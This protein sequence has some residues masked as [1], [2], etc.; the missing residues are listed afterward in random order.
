MRNKAA[1]IVTPYFAPQT[2]A[3]V[4]RAYKLAKYL[5][6]FG[7]R[8][9]VVTV[10]K[11]Y[12]Y[13]EDRSLTEAL[14]PEVEVYRARYVEPTLRG[15]R[16][17]LGGKDRTF[18]SLKQAG[19]TPNGAHSNGNGNGHHSPMRSAYQYA[20]TRWMQDPDP[21]W[22]WRRPAVRLATRLIREKNISVV[23]TSA[24]P[25]TCHQIGHELQGLGCRWVADLRD[26]HTYCAHMFSPH[27]A[28]FHHQRSAEKLA[29]RNADAVTVASS[30]IGMI[31]TDTYGLCSAERIH[32]IPTG[33]DEALLPQ[34][35]ET[36]GSPDPY[37]L[38]T[39]EFLPEYGSG[40][41][42]IFSRAMERVELKNTAW[43]LVFAGRR[44]VN[45]PLV[46][47]LAAKLGI[48]VRVQFIDHLPQT[49]LYRLLNGA[50]AAILLSGRLFR[51]W[52]L[53]AKMVDYI[54][55]KKPVIA[56][57]PDTSEARTRLGESRLGVFLDGDLEQCA[58]TLSD[59]LLG[60]VRPAD[61]DESVC[62]R[63]T[64]RQQVE[65][66]VNVFESIQ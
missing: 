63:Y 49:E 60:R 44:E 11:N 59:F 12:L 9:Y 52:C 22:T 66:F 33:L 39:G 26:P 7:W 15:L 4:F 14:P 21:Y 64:A 13:N 16:M 37:L 10:D 31:L 54:A 43:R 29:V 57:V 62:R 18:A 53:Y 23:F 40:F 65:S 50:A 42:E 19:A 34:P 32:F 55:M 2:H 27:A 38:F 48:E 5:P 8:P 17:A 25:F 24:N 61:P 46:R 41:L 1:L 36:T 58:S 45:E 30:A 20:L 47:P 28:V 35:A 6:L 51:W 3:A 56:L